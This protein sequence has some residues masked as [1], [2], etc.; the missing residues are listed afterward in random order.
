MDGERAMAE[1]VAI[2][3]AAL[4]SSSRFRT[5]RRRALLVVELADEADR[6]DASRPRWDVIGMA[7]L[8]RQYRG[9]DKIYR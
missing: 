1:L 7:W 9:K 2:L 6:V 5:L 3:T 8:V 4:A